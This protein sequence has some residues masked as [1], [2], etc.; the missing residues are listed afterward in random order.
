[1]L[2]SLGDALG[3]F[4]VSSN[5]TL[6]GLHM[7]DV[8]GHAVRIVPSFDSQTLTHIPNIPSTVR[9]CDSF[10]ILYVQQGELYTFV[11]NDAQSTKGCI[12]RIRTTERNSVHIIL[13]ARSTSHDVEI[14]AEL[15]DGSVVQNNRKIGTLKTNSPVSGLLVSYW[16]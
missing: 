3:F 2:Q 8:Q 9:F 14:I 1:M 11:G 16:C 7:S 13:K 6:Y 10:P 15:Y 4:D 12:L 5:V